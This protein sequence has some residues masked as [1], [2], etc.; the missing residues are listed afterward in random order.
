MDNSEYS[1]LFERM[2]SRNNKFLSHSL[3]LFSSAEE[4]SNG[5]YVF[6]EL[7]GTFQF[8]VCLGTNLKSY[9][10]TKSFS[11][12]LCK[13]KFE[14]ITSLSP[15]NLHYFLNALPFR[16]EEIENIYTL[17]KNHEEQE[18]IGKIERKFLQS[19][20]SFD[21]QGYLHEVAEAMAIEIQLSRPL[22]SKGMF[23]WLK[24]LS[25]LIG[26]PLSVYT[27]PSSI[28]SSLNNIEDHKISN[29]TFFKFDQLLSYINRLETNV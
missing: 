15:K 25:S 21:T 26:T 7:F 18:V 12:H 11:Q 2:K 27:S 5:L 28:N 24:R 3:I 16:K 13:L 10:E 6:I 17:Y 4:F 22:S 29:Y 19:Q 23:G 9:Y 8:Y 1:L 14:H 20:Y